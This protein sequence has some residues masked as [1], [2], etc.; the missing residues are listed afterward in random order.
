MSFISLT[1]IITLTFCH[2][3]IAFCLE[4]FENIHIYL[5]LSPKVCIATGPGELYIH[6]WVN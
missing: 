3:K 6:T 4:K 5:I 2:I 1:F